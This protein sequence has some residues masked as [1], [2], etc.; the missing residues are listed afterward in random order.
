MVL[1][2]REVSSARHWKSGRTVLGCVRG[3][4]FRRES[5]GVERRSLICQHTSVA[6]EV[7]LPG[8]AGYGVRL[9]PPSW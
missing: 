1:F 8:E 3:G 7:G 9:Y 2:S 6:I 4:H 5:A